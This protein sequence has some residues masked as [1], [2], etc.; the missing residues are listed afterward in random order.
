ML[1]IMLEQNDESAEESTGS[2]R[3][4]LFTSWAR[5]GKG[6]W[7]KTEQGWIAKSWQMKAKKN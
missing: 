2:E 5:P 7:R 6:E 3:F 1:T 4:H